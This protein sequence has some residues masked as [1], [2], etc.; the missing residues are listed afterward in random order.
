MALWFAAVGA[1]LVL[2]LAAAALI[3]R[4]GRT[5][6]WQPADPRHL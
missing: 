1:V 5:R 4:R 3:V 6:G 2:L